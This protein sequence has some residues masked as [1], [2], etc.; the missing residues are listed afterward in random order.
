MLGSIGNVGLTDP[1]AV[2]ELPVEAVPI[3]GD[4]WLLGQPQ[5]LCGD[6]TV[7]ADVGKVL[8][9]VRQDLMVTDP[10]P[11]RKLNPVGVR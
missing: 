9:R 6:S 5:L 7:A 8:G 4:L 10:C 2:P 11:Y 3:P 1:D